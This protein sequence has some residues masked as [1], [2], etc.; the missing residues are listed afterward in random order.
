MSASRYSHPFRSEVHFDITSPDETYHSAK[1]AMS[2]T[3]D[4]MINGIEFES[5]IERLIFE[6]TP[7]SSSNPMV[8]YLKAGETIP[9]HLR[10]ERIKSRL[11]CSFED[12]KRIA[13]AMTIIEADH[14]L[15]QDFIIEAK[16]QR[17]WGLRP[18]IGQADRRDPKRPCLLETNIE[19]I[20]RLA[21]KLDLVTGQKED[22]YLPVGYDFASQASRR[23]RWSDE[24]ET[25]CIWPCHEPGEPDIIP[26]LRML[27]TELPTDPDD[28]VSS[29]EYG[30]H[31]VGDD[32]DERDWLTD[33]PLTY[34]TLVEY[35]SACKSAQH[36][37]EIGKLMFSNTWEDHVK[38]MKAERF[39]SRMIHTV[40]QIFRGKIEI[41]KLSP[42]PRERDRF[43]DTDGFCAMDL[44]LMNYL[45]FT[46]KIDRVILDHSDPQGYET[47]LTWQFERA[48]QWLK[49]DQTA[50]IIAHINTVTPPLFNSGQRDYFWAMY[51][52][53]KAQLAPPVV[54]NAHA[55][56]LTAKVAKAAT[57]GK[58]K[59]LGKQMFDYQ[60]GLIG[61][62]R[63]PKCMW[64]LVWNVYRDRKAEFEP[65]AATV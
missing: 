31:L 28:S 5:Q 50:Q 51:R 3:P 52:I 29:E 62:P 9:R 11:V 26:E 59:W 19:D 43:E 14:R 55:E 37:A 61:T 16:A 13:A 45:V 12:A 54:L 41:T 21:G 34:R 44:A 57:L 49:E 2:L 25:A 40:E 47:R 1:S 15:M 48:T 32:P 33:Q 18:N 23:G 6:D 22:I 10:P 20:E 17:R 27:E 7:A 8:P 36:L 58:L 46:D 39:T 63:I 64:K 60:A 65:K 53:R 56:Y 42:I 30:Y 35:V 4:E 24:E 38:I